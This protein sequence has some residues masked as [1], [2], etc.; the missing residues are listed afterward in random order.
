[1]TRRVKIVSVGDAGV[2]K[3]SLLRAICF[4]E[5]AVLQEPPTVHAE[6]F[7]SAYRQGGYDL[8]LTLTDTSGQEAYKA[9][10]PS[11]L[12]SAD[13]CFAVF[14]LDDRDSFAHIG[15]W[16]A[17]VRESLAD[18]PIVLV[19]NKSDL[20]GRAVAREEAEEAAERLKLAKYNETSAA[21][22]LGA[23]EAISDNAELLFRAGQAR[24]EPRF[25][26]AAGESKCC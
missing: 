15:E 21:T 26:P 20:P 25:P 12:R 13:L 3:T 5:R 11:Y 8:E 18:A 14:A 1:M 6:L 4:N 9:L 10:A 2:G 24:Q 7:K 17:L 16:V 22:L 23:R 19:G